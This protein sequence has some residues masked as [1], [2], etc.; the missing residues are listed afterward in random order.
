MTLQDI[1][2]LYVVFFTVITTT[3]IAAALTHKAESENVSMWVTGVVSTVIVLTKLKQ[4]R[5]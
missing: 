4:C 2:N 5:C 1:V 3:A